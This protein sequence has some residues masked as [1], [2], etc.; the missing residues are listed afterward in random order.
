MV[1]LPNGSTLGSA[2]TL[3]LGTSALVVKLSD[4]ELRIETAHRLQ[5]GLSDSHVAPW[6]V[7]RFLIRHENVSGVARRIGNAFGDPSVA[8]R[9]DVRA[10]NR[11]MRRADRGDAA[12]NGD[13]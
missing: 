1:K 13:T 8:G 12:R 7:L 6:N 4:P 10:A 3:L 2:V 9:G 11:R 5:A